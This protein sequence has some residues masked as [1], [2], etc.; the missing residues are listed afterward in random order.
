MPLLPFPPLSPLFA[1][2]AS[3]AATARPDCTR[4]PWRHLAAALLLA[5]VLP[6]PANAATA[7]CDLQW[8]ITPQLQTTPRQLLLSLSFN[9]GNR[10]ST[11]LRLP[12]GWQG[13]SALPGSPALTPVA[14]DATLRSVEHA[15]GQPVTLRWQQQASAA[16]PALR[17]DSSW[18]A[19]A[20]Q[21]VLPV[22]D[23]PLPVTGQSQP[24]APQTLCV[25][26]SGLAANPGNRFMA[27][28]GTAQAD[29]SSADS[30]ERSTQTWQLSGS[31]ALVQQALFAGGALQLLT[32]QADGQA[33]QLLL[34]AS[35]GFA[36]GAAPLADAVAASVVQQRRFW[37]DSA[38]NSAP[39]LQLLLLPAPARSAP[40]AA[41]FGNS[42]LLSAPPEL[43]LPSAA[44][45]AALTE[46]LLRQRLPDRLGPLVHSGRRDEALR[47]WLGEGLVAFY[48]HRLLLRSGAWTADDYAAE[49]NRRIGRYLASPVL[50]A[51]NLKVATG[52]ASDPQLAE[53]PALRGE[54]LAL[55]WHA[56][57]RAAGQ[58][59]L[60]GVL[61]KL[62]LP[63]SQARHEGP[64]SSPLATHRLLAALRHTLGDAPLRDLTEHID[65]GVV[66]PFT[67]G[68][69]GPCFKLSVGRRPEWRLGFDRASLSA[70]VVS[71]VEAGGPAAAAGLRD[72]MAIR[73]YRVVHGDVEQPVW[74]QVVGADGQLSTLSYTAAGSRQR[75]LP[76]YAP[77][78]QA[79]QQGA[80]QGWLGQSAEAE[81]EI[82]SARTPRGRA[83]R[84]AALAATQGDVASGGRTKAGSKAKAAK[85]SKGGK[86][87]GKASGKAG[88]SGAKAAKSSAKASAAKTAKKPSQ[89]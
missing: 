9:P 48:S 73:G 35:A 39:P 89:R 65:R 45:D 62:M 12:A 16:N 50:E 51:D 11:R 29:I 83:A 22:P 79:L 86:S 34:P 13:I 85:S 74:L 47:A 37:R 57:L 10:S 78:A 42:L 58:P 61:R 67:A 24:A 53:L 40:E 43:S 27:S 19:V 68:T 70:G 17:L 6:G 21:A 7:T 41:A 23:E 56:A 84:A 4:P 54:W 80:C 26:L 60:D 28:A 71:G 64:L 52:W 1:R 31:P 63:A 76:Q 46:A 55:Q 49:L 2:P 38:D 77:V 15:A 3:H 44:L 14:D 36:Q 66:F 5:L 75:E 69:L 81:A 32:R 30:S 88:K 20:G 59:G 25:T 72:G 87:A 82:A 18:L 8:Q 33:L